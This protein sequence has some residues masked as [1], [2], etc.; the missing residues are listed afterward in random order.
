LKRFYLLGLLLFLPAI[1]LISIITLVA[2]PD[3]TLAPENITL[4]TTPITPVSFVESA[5]SKGLQFEHQRRSHGLNSIADSYGNGI[6]VIDF[7]NDGFDDIFVTAGLGATRRYGKDHWWNISSSSILYRNIDGSHF[8][9]VQLPQ[10]TITGFGC[11]IGD[12]NNDGLNDIVVGDLG[13]V[14]LLLNGAESFTYQPQPLTSANDWPTSM[15]VNDINEDG[16]ADI[17]IATLVNYQND[18]KVGHEDYGYQVST[19]FGTS[20]YT[21]QNNLVLLGQAKDVAFKTHVLPGQQRTLSI[22]PASIGSFVAVNGKGSNTVMQ[23]LGEAQG[24]SALSGLTFPA[25]QISPIKVANENYFVIANHGTSGVQLINLE[26]KINQAWAKKL[27]NDVIDASQSWATLVSDFNNDGLADVALASGFATPAINMPSRPQG[28][29]N[30]LLF[31]D[32]NGGFKA[33]DNAFKPKLARSSR[34]ATFGDFNNDGFVDMAFLNNNNFASLYLNEGND[35][36]WVSFICQPLALCGGSQWTVTAGKQI[37]QQSWDRVQPYLSYVS[38]RIHFGLGQAVNSVKLSVAGGQYDVVVD[39]IYRLDL[40]AGTIEP[41][42]PKIEQ[43]DAMDSDSLFHAIIATEN[44]QQLVALLATITLK[45]QQATQLLALLKS[46]RLNL[47]QLTQSADHRVVVTLAW[48]MSQTSTVSPL[49]IDLLMDLENRVFVDHLSSMVSSLYNQAFCRFTDK[50]AYWFDEEEVL[51]ETK[52][53]LLPVVLHQG[54]RS[55]SGNAQ[56]FQCAIESV[57]YSAQTTIGSSLL[58]LLRGKDSAAIIR[59]I[60]R[61]KFSKALPQLAS[62]CQQATD[63]LVLAECQ[64][65]LFKL[66][67]IATPGKAD[68]QSRRFFAVHSDALLLKNINLKLPLLQSIRQANYHLSMIKDHRYIGYQALLLQGQYDLLSQTSLN[69]DKADMVTFIQ[70]VKNQYPAEVDKYVQQLF[71]GNHALAA[72]LLPFVS[73]STLLS[74]IVSESAPHSQEVASKLVQQCV[75]R[76][77]LVAPCQQH[78][79]VKTSVTNLSAEK[80]LSLPAVQLYYLIYAASPVHKQVIARQ[81]YLGSLKANLKANF[82]TSAS[83]IFALLHHNDLYRLIEKAQPSWVN[84]FLAY[85]FKTNQAVAGV[86]LKQYQAQKYDLSWLKLYLKGHLAKGTYGP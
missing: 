39:T 66:T 13:K 32:H 2:R 71:A 67:G 75:L 55:M 22:L 51:P 70:R 49:L 14:H 63:A 50:L 57:S 20:E 37:Y 5:I 58:P 85:S 27:T 24:D 21:G 19:T 48:L 77:T 33:A 59:A 9:P 76:Q 29:V 44:P 25:V 53:A 80:L 3:N 30:H 78:F 41:L 35:N 72:S 65:S 79:G 4:S 83:T 28:A 42:Q 68:K 61:L 69:H 12:I 17:L 40:A 81:L 46:Y 16:L 36:H 10:Q 15:L 74:F 23:H 7:D 47:P 45:D 54:L 34:G 86:W 8:A 31:Q 43:S 1:L 18:L 62:F 60:G 56:R 11:T 38:Q 52:L 6:C 82:K 64:I 84:D 73:N 26:Q